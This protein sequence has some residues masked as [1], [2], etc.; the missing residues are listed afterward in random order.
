MAQGKCILISK[1]PPDVLANF[2]S[3]SNNRVHYKASTSFYL[4]SDPSLR[5]KEND[6]DIKK[7]LGLDKDAWAIE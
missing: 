6:L 4:Q 2:K 7:C 3:I 5:I 1:I